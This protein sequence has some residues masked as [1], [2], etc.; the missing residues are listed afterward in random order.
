ML[1]QEPEEIKIPGKMKTELVK[2]SLFFT[3]EVLLVNSHTPESTILLASTLQYNTLLAMT[4]KKYI[5][6]KLKEI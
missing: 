6:V 3:S 1:Y 4:E 5:N 2:L